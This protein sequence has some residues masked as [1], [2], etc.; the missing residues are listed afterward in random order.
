MSRGPNKRKILV[1]RKVGPNRSIFIKVLLDEKAVEI[2]YPDRKQAGFYLRHIKGLSVAD[3]VGIRE[4]L[5]E[6][7]EKGALSG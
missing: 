5:N 7:A 3:A 1:E 6:L 2:S 4:A